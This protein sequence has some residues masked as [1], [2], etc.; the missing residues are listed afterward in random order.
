MSSIHKFKN[1]LRQMFISEDWTTSSWAREAQG[2]R[3]AAIVLSIQFWRNIVYSLKVS[4]PIVKV[5]RMVDGERRP[6]MGY[7]YE[8]MDRAKETIKDAFKGNELEYQEIWDIIDRRWDVQLHKP[9][10]AAGHILNPE[11]YYS[12]RERIDCDTEVQ[13]GLYNCIAKLVPS[14][15]IQDKITMELT[16]Y[17]EAEGLFGMDMAKRQRSTRSPGIIYFLT[18]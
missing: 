6:P 10:H 1:N 17:K 12:N 8:A 16:K 13:E 7:I 4:S 2:K 14:S 9:L 15:G 18:S 5:L 11:I 3:V